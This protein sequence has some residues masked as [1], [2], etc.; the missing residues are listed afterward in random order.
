MPEMKRLMPDLNGK[1]VLDIGCGMGHLIAHMLK[2]HPKHITGIDESLNMINASR[3]NS[4]LTMS[5]YIM[6][7]LWILIRMKRMM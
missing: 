2:L 5:R 1:T 6:N 7:H 3:E 4:I